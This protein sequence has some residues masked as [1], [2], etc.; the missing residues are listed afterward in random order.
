MTLRIRQAEKCGPQEFATYD[1]IFVMRNDYVD[2]KK[3]DE[4]IDQLRVVIFV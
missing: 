2:R 3:D 1:A 4:I